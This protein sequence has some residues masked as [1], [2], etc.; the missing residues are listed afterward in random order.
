MCERKW[1]LP[2]I[3]DL[4]K[5]QDAALAL[6]VDGQHLI[7]GGPGTGKSVVALLRSRQLGNNKAPYIFLVYNHMLH[8][9]S[10][11]LVG[12]DLSS[13]TY[14]RWFWHEFKRRTGNTVPRIT[15]SG[16]SFKPVDWKRADALVQQLR[17]KGGLEERDGE[18]HRA[19]VI[20]EGQD[21]PP[22]FYATLI[23]LGFENFFV[24]ADQNQQITE[25]NSSRRDLED[26]LAL[27][28]DQVLELTRNFRNELGVATLAR[29]FYTGDPA[30]PSP[31]LPKARRRLHT[32]IL[33]LYDQGANARDRIASAILIHADR[34]RRRLIG[35]L[36]PNNEIRKAYVEALQLAHVALDGKRPSI[37]TYANR[38]QPNV[39]FD[40]GG[41]VVLNAQSCK[42]LEFDT[43]VLVEIDEHLESK[44]YPDLLKK[45]FY[46]MVSRAR[47]RV[48]MFMKRDT[49]SSVAELL[50]GDE[51][52]LQ[53]KER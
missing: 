38:M 22:Q 40:R 44:E 1:E 31:K 27:D 20:D 45:R 39:R 36:V 46:V 33:Y 15:D 8:T 26:C 25:E 5:E 49:H 42:G 35:V 23:K 7:I 51:A 11:Q 30:S 41:I 12:G 3:Q 48:F 16:K 17:E 52:V 28:T 10:K 43:V 47:E 6:P 19:L 24:V 34:D 9:A 32:P 53:R 37:S 29:V 21:M 50:P 13:E 14:N 2:G 4:T 18:S